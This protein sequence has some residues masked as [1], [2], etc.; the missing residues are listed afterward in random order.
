MTALSRRQFLATTATAAGAAAA[1]H[2]WIRPAWAQAKEVRVLAWTHFVPAYDKW[3]DA[4]AEQW[5]TKNNVKVTIDHIPHL[6]I[7]AKIAAEIATQSGHDIVQLVGSGTEKWAAA[8]ADVN[9]V[10]DRL[11]KKHGGFT[12]LAENYCK[13]GDGKYHSVPDF[14]I[15]FPG[16][17][18]KDLWTEVGMP[19]GP[20]TWED[21]RVGGG[22]L[23]KKNF[24]VGIGLAHHDDSRASWRA[25]MWS[26]GA[27]EVTKD[28]KTITYNS[29]EMREALKFNKAL[30]K[31]AMTPEVLAWDDASNNR[32][33]ASGRGSWIHNPISAYRSIEGQ[34][35]DLADKIFVQLSPKGP[36]QRRSFANCRAYGVTKFSK[37]QDGAKAFLEA[38]VDAYRDGARA[39]T[40]YNMPFLKNFGKPPFPVIS[41]DPKLKPLEQ[42]AEYH[43]TTGYPGPLTPAADEVYQQFVMVDALAQFCADKMDLEQTVKWGEEKIKAIY[44]KFA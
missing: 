34:N 38:L 22:K 13:T 32:F 21:L 6:Q 14:F 3:F 19:N 18:R 24:P 39:S 17:Y 41:E 9:D 12:P 11:G 10:C 44:A 28:G 43:F 4:F 16:L 35:K 8:L 42:D 37:N 40:G 7:P 23:K 27:S 2:A 5:S 1:P 15:D 26:Y 30:Y 29:K 25:I 36:A 31:E 33:L 20:E